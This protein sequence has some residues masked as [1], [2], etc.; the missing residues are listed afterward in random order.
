M[1]FRLHPLSFVPA[2]AC[3][4]GMSGCV[5]DQRGMIMPIDTSYRATIIATHKDGFVTPDGILW[6]DGDL[7]L[8]D[9]G[10]GALR[11]WGA[12]GG[13]TTL[14]DSSSGIQEPEDLVA[15]RE[16]NVFFTDD[17]AGGVWEIDRHGRV[18]LLAGRDKGLRSTEGIALAPSGDI[19]VGDA[20]R[21]QVFSVNRA[22][23]VSV[24]LGRRYGI[25]KAESMVFGEK[26][27]L[28]IADNVDQ[29]VYLLTPK[30]KLL[31][32]LE[33]REGFSPETIWYD[34]ETLYITDSANGKLWRYTPEA[35]LQTMAVFGGALSHV[36]GITT[37]N[38]GGI[39]VSIPD[40]KRGVGYIIKLAPERGS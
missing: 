27:E 39:F 30:M 15:D 5:L 33:K 37:D 11:V 23:K 40:L 6:R 16:G 22:G 13:L 21:R 31:R 1:K 35:G 36:A 32:L 4:L 24:F 17:D 38:D 18:F 26:G 28:Y 14:A 25:T 7:V 29:V 9:E 3:A 12:T 20:L 19:L 34:N 10:A 2:V 8:A